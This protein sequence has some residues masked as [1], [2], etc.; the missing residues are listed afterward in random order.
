MH[1][2]ER[3]TTHLKTDMA[4]ASEIRFSAIYRRHSKIMW[5]RS[6]EAG[7]KSKVQ[8]SEPKTSVLMVTMTCDPVTLCLGRTFHECGVEETWQSFVAA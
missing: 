7:L 8:S 1:V 6:K 5:E 2:V 4:A 3:K